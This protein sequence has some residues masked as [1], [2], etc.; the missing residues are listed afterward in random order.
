MG[1][2]IEN[3]L[4]KFLAPLGKGALFTQHLA[5]LINYSTEYLCFV[6]TSISELEFLIA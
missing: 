4:S 6:I 2:L 5:Y 1:T 3:L